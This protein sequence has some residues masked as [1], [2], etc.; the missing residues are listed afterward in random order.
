MPIRPTRP[1]VMAP[2][3][4]PAP[5]REFPLQDRAVPWRLPPDQRQGFVEIEHTLDEESAVTEASRMLLP[6]KKPGG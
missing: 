6:S 1:P 5:P 3:P 4:A 2:K